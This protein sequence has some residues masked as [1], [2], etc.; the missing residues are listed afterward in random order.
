MLFKRK[1]KEDKEQNK[2]QY[3]ADSVKDS[4][5]SPYKTQAQ[6]KENRKINK[7]ALEFE[8]N[9]VGLKDREIKFLRVGL[10]GTFAV[11]MLMGV[12]LAVLAP[13]KTAVPYV[14]RVDNTTGFVDK[15]EP[16]NASKS[17]VDASVARY[18]IS[19]YI[20]DRESYDW[21]NVQALYDF[22]QETSSSTVFSSYNNMMKSE[23]S[24]LKVLNKNFKMNA[25]VNSITLLNPT[26][27]QVRFT[28]RIVTTGDERER[29]F[30]QTK[31]LAT[32]VFDFDKDV[33]TE[34]QR[35]TNPL[36]FRVNS[37]KLDAEVSVNE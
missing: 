13:F 7:T 16:Y 15:I 6:K 27:A 14:L 3:F 8:K 24:P 28:K 1:K 9:I 26:T 17:N 34:K 23:D 2:K 12:A 32:V 21:W 30:P 37:Y 10:G 29:A 36:G 22:V 18:F 5:E 35:M 4:V 33:K 11:I 19:K 31:W 20:T 25:T